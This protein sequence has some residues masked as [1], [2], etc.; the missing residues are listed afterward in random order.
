MDP[1]DSLHLEEKRALFQAL[2]QNFICF[3]WFYT[4]MF[5]PPV[6]ESLALVLRNQRDRFML[7]HVAYNNQRINYN[8][9]QVLFIR[10]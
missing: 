8:Q 7:E 2:L 9:W 1:N 3:E 10:S 5:T 4:R 6:A